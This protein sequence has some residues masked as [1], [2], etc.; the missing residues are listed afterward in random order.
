MHVP[1]QG[2]LV[3]NPYLVSLDRR[4]VRYRAYAR[5]SDGRIQ[6]QRVSR[7]REGHRRFYVPRR[8]EVVRVLNE[9]GMLPAIYFVFSRAGCDASVR[10]LM[11]AG[12]RLTSHA[13]ADRIREIVDTRT[14]WLEEEDV[15]ALG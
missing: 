8:E 10:Y 5:V 14:A 15:A 2:H 3:P 12:V 1:T 7:P 9:E 11:D 6:S 4:E 13:E